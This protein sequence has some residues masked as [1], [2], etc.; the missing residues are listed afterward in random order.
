LASIFQA[1]AED[2]VNDEKEKTAEETEKNIKATDKETRKK[3]KELAR[4]KITSTET[5]GNK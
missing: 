2:Q 5:S 1:K 4:K 3:V